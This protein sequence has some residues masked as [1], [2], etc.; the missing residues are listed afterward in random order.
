MAKPMLTR[1]TTARSNASRHLR[2]LLIALAAVGLSLELSG[3][4]LMAVG[5]VAAGSYA[6]TDRRTLG[7]QTDDKVIPVKVASK[8]SDAVGDANTHINVTGFNRKVL[9][10]GEVPTDQAKD[11]AGRA[12][13][14]VEDVTGVV[15][16]LTV[17]GP[18]SLT[19]RTSD[20]VI[21]TEV[22]AKFVS[23]SDIFGNAYK[24]VTERGSVYLMGRVT[25]HEGDRAAELARTVG[26][27]QRVVKVFDYI[28]ED[29]LK[30]LQ[31]QPAPEGKTTNQP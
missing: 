13:A 26:G 29:E 23:S 12:A 16:E 3:C 31:S 2:T 17:S 1:S 30:Q 19:S 4:F 7:A 28:S 25:Q 24:V 11:A 22:K 10:T 5:A 8:I 27:V 20:A 9:L 18:S 14:G 6:A 15:N 21:T